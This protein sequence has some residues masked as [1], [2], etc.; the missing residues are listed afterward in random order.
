MKLFGYKVNEIPIMK[1]LVEGTKYTTCVL[2][3][4]LPIYSNIKHTFCASSCLQSAFWQN[5]NYGLRELLIVINGDT[6]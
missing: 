2:F 1:S 5:S 6:R 4:G 3:E